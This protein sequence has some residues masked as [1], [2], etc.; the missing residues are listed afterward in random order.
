MSIEENKAIIRRIVEE[1]Y[2]KGNLA[3]VDGITASNYLF[4]RPGM[5]VK[6]REG[7]KQQIIAGIRTTF[8]DLHF[9]I[10]DMF[11]EEDKV[12]ARYTMTATHKGEFM[13]IPPTGKKVTVTGI[14][15]VHFTG[16]KQVESWGIMDD[17]G[18]MQQM[19]VV[20]P[21]GQG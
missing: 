3:V 16:G 15:I 17:L 10:N 12:A 6:G 1:A 18:M 2:N 5:E 9:A 8:P 13:G 19:G 7:Y 11:A 20:P 21:M 4:H 14:S